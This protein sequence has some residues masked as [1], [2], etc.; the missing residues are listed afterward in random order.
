MPDTRPTLRAPDHVQA[1][2]KE[3]KRKKGATDRD[4]AYALADSLMNTVTESADVIKSVWEALPYGV[5]EPRRY[6]D[7]DQYRNITPEQMMQDIWDHWDQ[8]DIGRAIKNIIIDQAVDAGIALPN[9]LARMSW[10]D[11]MKALGMDR[12]VGPGTGGINRFTQQPGIDALLTPASRAVAQR[13]KL[14]GEPNAV[15]R[16]RVHRNVIRGLP[17]GYGTGRARRSRTRIL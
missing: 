13:E 10:S 11:A 5:R 2:E 17:P 16:Y 8:L 9:M 6:W 7:G 3:R 4:T 1:R 12:P 14:F 15:A